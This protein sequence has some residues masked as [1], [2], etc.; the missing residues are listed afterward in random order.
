MI[1]I[2]ELLSFIVHFCLSLC[3][4][5][6]L[7][8]FFLFW[9]LLCWYN[10][11]IKKS[12]KSMERKRDQKV[13]TWKWNIW[14]RCGRGMKDDDIYKHKRRAVVSICMSILFLLWVFHC[15]FVECILSIHDQEINSNKA[16]YSFYIFYFDGRTNYELWFYE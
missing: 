11:Y 13:Y 15:Q 16:Q 2:L 3:Y 8:C 12:N 5:I 9:C 14:W 1:W 4:S 6:T 10:S 7:F